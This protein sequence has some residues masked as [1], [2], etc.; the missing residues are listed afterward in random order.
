MAPLS[1][2]SL[3]ALAVA[4]PVRYD[5]HQVL[6]VMPSS[7]Q[8]LEALRALDDTEEYD[9]WT[10]ARAVNRPVDIRCS[11][12]T[13][14]SL[15]ARLAEMGATEH[16]VMIADLQESLDQMLPKLGAS[17]DFTLDEYHTYDDI[18]AWLKSLADKYSDI[19]EYVTIG[20]SYEGREMGAIKIFGKNA[21]G[22][23]AFWM[24]GGIH[25]REWITTAT[26]N[27]MLAKTLEGYGS[28]D[29]VTSMVDG[30]NIYYA[31]VLNPDGYDYTWTK[32]RMQ[33]KTMMPN[34]CLF[35]SPGT[36]PN[37]NWDFH[38]GEAGT[39]TNPCSESYQGKAAADQPEVAAV[40]DFIREKDEF[41]GYIN[42]HSYSQLWMSP[43]GYTSDKAPDFDVQNEAAG[44]AVSALQAVH[45]TKFEYGPI[46]TTIYPASGSSADYTYGKCG[47][48]FSYGVELRDT[49][50]H[51]F[52]L[53]ATEIIPS[54]EETF[55]AVKALAKY[56]IAHDASVIV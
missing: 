55:E 44:K 28:D 6:R 50:K 33:R 14:G 20:K 11:A 30:L 23:K 47:V 46:S 41:L 45:G 25:A 3:F 4:D 39:S 15:R 43:W 52:T 7:Q 5:G 38:W 9:F 35:G 53:P 51:G 22:K 17:A 29:A 19:C 49:G 26:V 48:L 24:D 27:Y 36:D 16:S 10:D 13:C 21:N 37:R 32:D 12:E 1:A 54:G 42:F 56:M 18:Q 2:F 40:Q 34:S 8:Q 31:P